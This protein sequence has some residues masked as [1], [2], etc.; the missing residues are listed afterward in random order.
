MITRTYAGTL[1]NEHAG[2]TVTLNGWVQKRR[3]FGDLVFIDLRD[4]SGVVQIVVDLGRGTAA[5]VVERAKELRSEF[6]VRIEGEVV[7]RSAESRNSKM[8][9]GDI[10]V[11]AR[12]VEILN[13]ADTPP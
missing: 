12:G 10:E 1:R 13:R 11:I 9:T 8:P 4:R 2:T 7:S 3:D 6:V 5:D